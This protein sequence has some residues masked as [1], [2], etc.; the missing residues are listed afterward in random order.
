M[1]LFERINIDRKQCL[2]DADVGTRQLL[3]MVIAKAT[4]VNKVPEDEVVTSAIRNL[5]KGAKELIGI[6]EVNH[7]PDK[8]AL[9]KAIWEIQ[10]LEEY[11]PKQYDEDTLSKLINRSIHLLGNK[12][13]K[14]IMK[15]LNENH[16]GLFDRGMASK[17]IKEQLSK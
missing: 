14:S 5:I 6:L 4:L 3:G 2:K 8:E 16:N 12:D 9:E 15:Y 17:I 1:T 13:I 11:L 7:S 10:V